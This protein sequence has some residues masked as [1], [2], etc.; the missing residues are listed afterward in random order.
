M[1]NTIENVNWGNTL[2]PDI[3]FYTTPF[4][5]K[6]VETINSCTKATNKK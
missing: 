2:I 4:V 1:K 3:N 6:L 5:N